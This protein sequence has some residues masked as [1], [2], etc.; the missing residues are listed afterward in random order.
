MQKKYLKI[1]GLSVLV[2]LILIL[3]ALRSGAG[4]KGEKDMLKKRRSTSAQCI[5]R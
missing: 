5:L 4:K 3:T 2:L 1:A